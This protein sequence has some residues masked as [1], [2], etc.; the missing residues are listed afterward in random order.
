MAEVNRFPT[1]VGQIRRS[2]SI[3]RVACHPFRFAVTAP[4][5][6]VPIAAWS[7]RLR[8]LEDLGFDAVTLPDHFTQGHRTEPLVGLTAAAM[9]TSRLRLQTCVLG[10]DYRH[11]VLVHRMLATLDVVS[12][13]RVVIGLGAGWMATDYEAAGLVQEPAGVRISRLEEAVAIV[14]GLFRPEPLDFT[15]EHYRVHA[16]QGSPPPVQRPRPPLFLGG[17]GRRMLRFAGAQAD[18]VGVNANL[19]EGALGR[20]TVL[21]SAEEQITEKLGWIRDGA[22]AAGRDPDQLELSLNSWL[23]RVTATEREAADHLARA[24]GKLDVP[25]ALLARA[26]SV[27]V[28][29]AGRCVE[30]LQE[31]RERFG[32]NRVQLDAGFSPPDL[33]ALAPLLSALAGR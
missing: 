24:A 4:D 2:R 17:G 28:G 20:H 21:D 30:L 25:A 1:P 18:I 6:L 23:V 33:D 7:A 19:G 10:V 8:H 14:T 5:P 9:A 11:P 29:T 3:R 32:F 13:G 31:R 15:G 27:L 22:Q 12:E 26:P 16:L